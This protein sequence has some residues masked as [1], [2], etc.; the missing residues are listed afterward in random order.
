MRKTNFGQSGYG[1]IDNW[2]T[3]GL[4]TGH[5]LLNDIATGKFVGIWPSWGL[6]RLVPSNR[7]LTSWRGNR[8]TYFQTFLVQSRQNRKLQWKSR[9]WK[10]DTIRK[11]CSNIRKRKDSFLPPWRAPN[12]ATAG[13]QLVAVYGVNRWVKEYCWWWPKHV[14]FWAA[15]PKNHCQHVTQGFCG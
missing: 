2:L 7:A 9:S 12:V 5:F 10:W 1:H 14:Y 6:A 4:K 15:F 8:E 11:S 13:T 3:V